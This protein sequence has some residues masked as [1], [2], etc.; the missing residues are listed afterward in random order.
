MNEKMSAATNLLNWF[1][2]PMVV[3]DRAKNFYESVFSIELQPMEMNGEPMLFF[4]N[5]PASGRV[6]GSLVKSEHHK[7]GFQG[8]I[9]YLNANPA[10]SDIIS[11]IEQNGGTILMPAT[12]VSPE[13][14]YIALFM[15][16]EGNK[17][18]LHA[19]G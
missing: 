9:V 8:A 14:G 11:K 13:I 4:P 1:E 5:D 16:S 6:G 15:D 2:L 3:V 10:I 17:V 12:Q 19:N 7:P 18:G